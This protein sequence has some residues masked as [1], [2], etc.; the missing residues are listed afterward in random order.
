[1]D[2]NPNSI[3]AYKSTLTKRGAVSGKAKKKTSAAPA[4]SQGAAGGVSV[5]DIQAVK[6]LVDR[7]GANQVQELAQVLAE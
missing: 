7:L 6:R 4:R 3:S 5:E 1:M 2:V